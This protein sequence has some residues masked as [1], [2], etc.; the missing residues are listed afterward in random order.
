[1]LSLAGINKRI[2]LCN[3]LLMYLLDLR[4]LHC[5]HDH[6]RLFAMGEFDGMTTWYECMDCNMMIDDK[7]GNDNTLKLKYNSDKRYQSF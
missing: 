6:I 5:P 2:T 1:M 4:K 3:N 7:F